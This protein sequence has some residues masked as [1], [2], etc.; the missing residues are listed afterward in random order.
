[1]NLL[2]YFAFPIATIIISAI[3]QKILKNPIAVAALT[4]AIFLVVTFAA[5]DETFLIAT[6]AYTVIS[7]ITAFI[8]SQINNNNDN[9]DSD[10]EITTCNNTNNTTSCGCNRYRRF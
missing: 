9:D 6:L 4:F 1:M 8:V 3:L 2:I 7:L 5:F 10:D